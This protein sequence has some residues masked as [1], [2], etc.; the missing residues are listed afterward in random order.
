MT[1]TEPAA[2]HDTWHALTQALLRCPPDQFDDWLHQ[3]KAQLSLA[4]LQF[5]KETEVTSAA[6]LRDP[7]TMDRVTRYALQIAATLPNDL[8]AMGLAQWMRG[9]WAM[10][11]QV[12][13]AVILFKAALPAFQAVNDHLSVAKLSANLVGV[14]ADV[15]ENAQ[16][17]QFYQNA[18]A[19]FLE[20][21]DKEPRYLVVLEQNFGYLLHY[22]GRYEEALVVHDR[23]LALAT[24]HNM[25]AI[26]AEI[27]VNRHL[28]LGRLGRFAEVE[29]G[30]LQARTLAESVEQPM[31]VARIDI[32]L[33]ELYTILGQP[34]DALRRFQ[35]A[36]QALVPMEQGPV[37]ATQATLLRHLASFHSARL[38]YEA[39]LELLEQYGLK[40]FHA[41]TLVNLA[42][43]LRQDGDA[44]DQ[45]RARKLLAQAEAVW[46]EHDNP[47]GLVQVYFERILLAHA[48]GKVAQTTTLIATPPPLLD[49]PKLQAEFRLLRAESYR[50]TGQSIGQPQCVEDYEA[51][52]HYAT[53]AGMHWLRRDALAG[54]GKLY[55]QSNWQKAQQLLETAAETDDQMRQVLSVEELKAGFH[56]H[57][58]DLYHSL[59]R[60]AFAQQENEHLLHYVWRA[61]A[62]AFLD[63]ALSKHETLVDEDAEHRRQIALLRQQ[64]AA[65]RWSLAMQ[66]QRNLQDAQVEAASPELNRLLDQ[67]LQLRQQGRRRRGLTADLAQE[68]IEQALRKL[69]ADLLIEYVRCDNELYG[70]CA[71][72]TGVVV[73]K[74]L[75]DSEVIEEIAGRLAHCVESFQRLSPAERQRVADARLDESRRYLAQ[76]Y[77]LLVAPLLV[78]IAETVAL[79][80]ILIAPCDLLATLPFAAFWTG[81]H[82]WIEQHEL[83]LIQSGALLLLDWPTALAYAPPVVAAAASG[84]ATAVRAEAQLVADQ[85]VDSALFV[86]RAVLTHLKELQRPP[87]LLHIA[88]HTIQRGDAP[89]FTGIQLSGE[90]LSVEESYDLPLWGTRLVTLSGC[91]TASGMESD[92]SL[93][94]F[95]S[96]FLIAGAQRVLCTLWPIADGTPARFMSFFY[97]RLAQGLNAPAALR[98]TQLQ[99]ITE[100]SYQHPALWAAFTLVRR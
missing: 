32:A 45:Q 90:V 37:L 78:E 63:L 56:R 12:A 13:D 58:N 83:E 10:H 85:L 57:A 65:L 29:A 92:A 8:L 4:F 51:V 48:Q 33:G 17:E 81:T 24:Q 91:T 60:G 66:E 84:N 94:A 70:I 76:C 23:A 26:M 88:A 18:R 49:N 39:A 59:I 14:L 30:F 7:Q 71:T 86:D 22:W 99:L 40:T 79:N 82:Y 69:D 42:I 68:P 61:K 3:H 44:K 34:L 41:E 95:Q 28:T 52:L 62:S 15:N 36:A 20:Y 96:A 47:Y 64:I 73:T 5:L 2:A 80:K 25:S 35:Q 74:R 38:Q 75:A 87:R 50:L 43:C 21:A 27:R 53:T 97:A 54:L 31:T 55:L 89:L 9:L 16:A 93:F 11:N 19:V 6:V 77:T 98:K 46:K 72:Q 100:A 67:L 1:Q